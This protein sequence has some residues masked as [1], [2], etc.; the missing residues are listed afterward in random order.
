MSDISSASERFRNLVERYYQ[1]WFRFH[2]EA[3]VDVGVPGYA[4]LLTPYGDNDKGALVCLNDELRVGLEELD[5]AALTPDEQI[6]RDIL[7]GAAQLE[8]QRL[9]DIEPNAPDPGK[10]LPVYA[11]YQLTIR[12]VD[13]LEAALLS[14]L[15]AIPAHLAGARDHLRPHAQ[16]I[17]LLWLE[18]AITAARRGTEFLQGLPLPAPQARGAGAHFDRALRNACEALDQYADYLQQEVT[19]VASGDFACHQTYFANMLHYRHFLDIEIDQLYQLGE[20]LFAQTERELKDVCQELYGHDDVGR[21]AKAIKADHPSRE[22]LLEVYRTQMQAARQFITARD[23]VTL[24]AVERLDVVET[25]LFMRHQVPFAAYQDPAA[26]DPQQHGYYYVT[27]P[28]DESQLAEHNYAGLMHT[29]VHEAYPGHHLQFVTAH[30][31]PRASTL[32]RLLQASST[33]YEGWALYCEQLMHEQGFLDRPEQRFLLLADRLWRALRILIDVEIHTRNTPIEQAAEL[34]ATQLGF[35]R[36]Q[37]LA[38]LRWYS[39]SP[40]V[41]MGY[42]TGWALINALRDRAG[43]QNGGGSLRE[44]HD[45]LLSAGSIALPLVIRRVFG[46]EMW[47]NVRDAV[48]HA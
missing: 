22:A 36:E 25:P 38:D 41:P 27:P 12:S 47:Q 17:P 23:L 5:R 28:Q 45:R 24:P 11:I 40:T 34:M 35:P 33:L 7:Y 32:P 3:A 26:N 2:P 37:A 20:R 43:P 14:R 42:A 46:V 18:S 21:A 39:R 48:F 9:L 19:G 10:L 16:K 6:D 31:N 29:C 1:A 8:N 15:E 30:L 13:D 4:H 44:F